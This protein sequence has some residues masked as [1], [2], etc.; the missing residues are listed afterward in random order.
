MKTSDKLLETAHEHGIKLMMDLV[1]NHTL[2]TSTNGL[3]GTLLQG[4][5]Y[6]D[7]SPHLARLAGFFGRRQA[8]PAEQLDSASAP[9]Y[10]VGRG[11]RPVSTRTTFSIKQP[12]PELRTPKVREEVYDIKALGWTRRGRL[13]HGRHQPD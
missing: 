1:V 13:P 3:A 2:R 10:G 8:D 9:P 11:D 7:Y 5:P 4:Q 12:G 6:R